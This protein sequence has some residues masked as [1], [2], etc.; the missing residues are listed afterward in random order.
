[1]N[2][3]EHV[4]VNSRLFSVLVLSLAFASPA[5]ANFTVDF[6][7]HPLPANSFDNG[8]N[9]SGGFFSSGAF[10][11]N[12]YHNE[13]GGYWNG[14]SLSNVNAPTTGGFGNQYAVVTGTTSTAS[15]T[16]AV[17]YD[18]GPNSSYINLPAGSTPLSIDVTNTAYAYYSMLNGDQFAKKFATGDFLQLQISGYTGASAT[19]TKVGEIDFNLANYKTDNDHPVNVWS[20]VN[21]SSLAS[22]QSLGFTMTSSDVGQFGINTPLYFAVDRIGLGG[23]ATGAAVPEPSSVLLVA[24]GLA[25]LLAARGRFRKI[26]RP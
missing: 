22:A 4:Q 10:L 11:N 2:I 16:Y 18:G 5:L 24:V 20:N 3:R 9:H 13:Y 21:I 26:T 1:M 12:Q 14:W 7:D 17:A 25:G 8:S 19:G 6:S 23:T 15:S